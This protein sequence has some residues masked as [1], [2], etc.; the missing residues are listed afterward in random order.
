MPAAP[1]PCRSTLAG[2]VLI[3]CGDKITTDHIMPAGTF[4]KHRSNVPEYAKV[5]FNRF[6]E[7]GKPTFAERALELKGK[8]TAASSWPARATARAPRASTRPC[9]R[10]TW[11]CGR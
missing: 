11:A 4:L 6:N 9:A 1:S 2:R 5:V 10:C 8:G 7:Q 3:K